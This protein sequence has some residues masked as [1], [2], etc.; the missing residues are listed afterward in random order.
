MNKYEVD[1]GKL[2]SIVLILI[3]VTVLAAIGQIDSA[4]V[5]LVYGLAA[6]YT[7][8]NG[9]LAAKGRDPVPMVGRKPTHDRRIDDAEG[10]T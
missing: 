9:R 6:G 8:G 10:E 2:A 3:G 7:F 1:I 5:N 4:T